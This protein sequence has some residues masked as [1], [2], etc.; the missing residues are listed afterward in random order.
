MGQENDSILTFDTESGKKELS[1]KKLQQL[2]AARE[3]ALLSR[4]KALK[5]KLEAKLSELRHVL[6]NDMRNSTVEKFA[7]AMMKQEKELRN[8]QNSMT[9]KLTEAINGFKDELA[10]VKKLVSKS[11]SVNLSQLSSKSSAP[12]SASEVSTNVSRRL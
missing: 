12:R 6:G 3:K 8:K 11:S 2:A 7:E 9:E 5:D 10:A 4:R 1:A